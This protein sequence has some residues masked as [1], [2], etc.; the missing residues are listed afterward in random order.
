VALCVSLLAFSATPAFAKR[1]RVFT[2]S[3]GGGI[4]SESTTI[5]PYPLGGPWSAAVDDATG[6]V[7]VADG[8]N[9]RVEEFTATGEFVLMFGKEV[10]KT[11]VMLSGTKEQQNVCTAESLDECQAGV[12]GSTPG[13]FEGGT[14]MN[15]AVD[16]SS[17]PSIGDVYVGDGGD[18]LVTKFTEKGEVVSTWGTGGQLA[19]DGAET[20]GEIRGVAVDPSGHLWVESTTI[21]VSE[22]TQEATSVR[23]WT[24]TEILSNN[25]SGFAVDSEE[26]IYINAGRDVFKYNSVG[27]FVGVINGS[28]VRAQ[29]IT[30]DS[31]NN[32]LYVESKGEP[33]LVRY[34]ASCQI[35]PF[36]AGCEPAEFFSASHL[37]GYTYGLAIDPS[38]PDEGETIYDAEAD[39][40]IAA[41]SFVTAPEAGTIQASG[42]TATE[43]TLNGA[44][45][46]AGEPVTECFFEWGAT[47][48][49]GN[50]APCEE[51]AAGE[52]TGVSA[53]PVK[54]KIEHL[55]PG[56]TYHF[57]LVAANANDVNAITD[58]PS[59]GH[60]LSFGPPQLESEFVSNVTATSA[61]FAAAANPNNVDT[62][63]R[64]EY[65]TTTGYG[66]TSPEVDIGSGAAGQ[67]VS[68]QIQGLAPDTVYHYHVVV[69][70]ALGAV[71]GKDQTFTTQR[72]VSTGEGVLADGRGWELVSPADKQGLIWPLAN[73]T[74][75]AIQA[76]ADGEAFTYITSAPTEADPLGNADY[77]QVLSTRT[78]GGWVSQD[79]EVPHAQPTGVTEPYVQEYHVFSSDLS[80][81]LL[82][83]LGGFDPSLSAQASE[84]TPYLRDDETGAFRPLVT[85]APGFANV[86]EDA[87]FGIN[88]TNGF[89][90]GKCP[91]NKQCGPVFLGATPNLE[92][93]GLTSKVPL[94]AGAPE[95]GVY[96]WTG[97]HLTLVS[98]LPGGGAV[99][100]LSEPT[101]G[102]P[103]SLP[104]VPN[105][106]SVTHAISADGNRVIWSEGR[107]GALYMRDLAR[108]ETIELPAGYEGANVSDTLVSYSGHECAVPD[109]AELALG[110]NFE[111]SALDGEGTNNPIE[112]GQLLGSSEDGSWVYYDDGGD[113][114]V[115]HGAGVASLIASSVGGQGPARVSPNGEWFAFMS[116]SS[117]TGYDNHDALSNEPDEEVFLYHAAASGA[118]GAGTLVCASCDP[119]GA[120]PHGVSFGALQANGL[121]LA[122]GSNTWPIGQW[123]AANLP[124]GPSNQ[125]GAR[126]L[127]NEG[128]LF[129][130]SSDA[131]VPQ[132]TNK[133]EDVYE[134]E[135]AVGAGGQTESGAAA[136]PND[137]CTTESLTYGSSSDGCVSLISSGTSHEESAFL[138][139][140]ENGDDVFFLTA[141]QLSLRDHDTAIDVYDA[142]VGGG[143]PQPVEP[144][145]CEGDA[146]QPSVLAPVHPTPGSLTF[147]GPG[148]LTSP[149][150]VV[151]KPKTAAQLKTEKLAKALKVCKQDK[152]KSKRVACEKQAKKK[153]GATKAK[154]S[155]K[156]NRRTGR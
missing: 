140:S 119:T 108:A 155:A 15:V 72:A 118:S 117:L 112:N 1:V 80:L 68:P 79:I 102:T 97:G 42:F 78:S 95:N 86:P 121:D 138:D 147:N 38:S 85:G 127:S 133:T 30:V 59:Y 76:A 37:G 5:N 67:S 28:G 11:E 12:A 53:V 96:E 7:Y 18:G 66:Q 129:F 32:D 45:N 143:E 123:L 74:N 92:H 35:R 156:T 36:G 148:N 109:E 107:S 25:I 126:F 71:P 27:G 31:A 50:K 49:Y 83:A 46:P 52:L 56:V 77:S 33:L 136:P 22:F 110:A 141:E 151:V 21:G 47:E 3:F 99:S 19:G 58:E 62:H 24:P 104:S 125:Y 54:A 65:G 8:E 39:G 9:N 124:G 2:G 60:D 23:H 20:F 130:N 152:K 91:P 81:G 63:V 100:P 89:A 149:V 93:I 128:R 135:P 101:L 116:D 142:R 4:G 64:F 41:F 40:E 75:F 82:Q 26:N 51:P 115:R 55:S 43:A 84:Q 139:A 153:Y 114:Y 88:Q 34:E 98:I 150:P 103:P 137:S 94:E 13:A 10:N 6:D 90:G 106:K 154:K 57:R 73:E 70:S 44:V 61:T 16:N 144:V 134:Y 120:R 111:C 131:L 145:E 29:G 132:D 105:S 146:C 113:F 48:S 69:H 14:I 122:A 17:G 87:E